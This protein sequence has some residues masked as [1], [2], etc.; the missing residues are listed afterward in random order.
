MSTN[1]YSKVTSG[2]N[3]PLPERATPFGSPAPSVRVRSG[4]RPRRAAPNAA[5]QSQ[6]LGCK[7]GRARAGR[8]RRRV[9]C[10]RR[11]RRR[12]RRRLRDGFFFSFLFFSFFV[13]CVHCRDGKR[14]ESALVPRPGLVCISYA[15][16]YSPGPLAK[17][18]GLRLGM[19]QVQGLCCIGR[20]PFT[21]RFNYSITT[22]R[23]G[24][25]V[26]CGVRCQSC[27]HADTP[28]PKRASHLYIIARD[29]LHGCG[30]IDSLLNYLPTDLAI[31]EGLQHNKHKTARLSAI[32]EAQ[33][34][35]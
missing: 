29:A 15:S 16:S 19:S 22:D 26:W 13:S 23:G 6:A 12:R 25:V 7:P 33:Q 10:R 9:N 1:I 24:G 8:W 3:H 31:L 32:R 28:R 2:I 11:R 21:W 4:T 17:T 5:Q 30:Q 35:K 20:G 27:W 14:T 18:T 34:S